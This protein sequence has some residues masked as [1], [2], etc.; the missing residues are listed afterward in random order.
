MPAAARTGKRTCGGGGGSL[1]T[2]VSIQGL[3]FREIGLAGCAHAQLA[4]FLG[5]EEQRVDEAVQQQRLDRVDRG[6][7]V[8]VEQQQRVAH[9]LRVR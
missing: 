2:A 9:L 5:L 8:E 6:L 7:V 3:R 1:E 4:P